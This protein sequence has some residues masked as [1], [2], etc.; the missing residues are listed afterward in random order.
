MRGTALLACGLGLVLAILAAGCTQ[1]QAHH[2]ANVAAQLLGEP[3]REQVLDAREIIARTRSRPMAVVLAVHL[4]RSLCGRVIGEDKATGLAV[5]DLGARDGIREGD[6]LLLFQYDR[7]LGKALV[8]QLFPERAAIRSGPIGLEGRLEAA[9]LPA[10]PMPGDRSRGRVIGVDRTN[11]IAI[12][13]LGEPQGVKK[14][15]EVIIARGESFIASATIFDV[16]IDKSA[17][18]LDP[19][20]KGMPVVGDQVMRKRGAR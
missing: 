8:E 19:K 16:M 2:E 3:P 6:M 7:F 11:G 18:R 20:M 10:A 1:P 5:I 15:E 13:D 4:G 9:P 12:L 17:A 14:G